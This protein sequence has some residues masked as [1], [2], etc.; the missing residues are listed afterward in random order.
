MEGVEILNVYDYVVSQGQV[1]PVLLGICIIVAVISFS[2]GMAGLVTEPKL[3]VIGFGIML[4]CFIGIF[5]SSRP[6]EPIIETRYEV[7]LSDKVDFNEFTQQ[8]KIIEQ[9]G[10]ILVIKEQESYKEANK[11][12]EI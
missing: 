4:L 2:V 7:T 12:A 6:K 8:Y 11:D 5:I 10:K 9:R 3:S 1:A